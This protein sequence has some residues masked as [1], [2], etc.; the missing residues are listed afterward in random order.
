[1]HE[2]GCNVTRNTA[3]V[4]SIERRFA[5]SCK[6][7]YTYEQPIGDRHEPLVADERAERL[8]PCGNVGCRALYRVHSHRPERRC[9][10]VRRGRRG[11][12]LSDPD[13][14]TAPARRIL[15]VQVS[16]AHAEGGRGR[17]RDPGRRRTR[18]AR[19]RLPPALVGGALRVRQDGSWRSAYRRD[20]IR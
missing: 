17:A 14:G 10:A 18:R 2:S 13:R 5:F 1:T 3:A 7:L 19:A 9:A 8:S 16:A 4:E 12:H 20:M 15:R 6:A 11:G